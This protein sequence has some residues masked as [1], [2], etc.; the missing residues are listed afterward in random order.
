VRQSEY[1]GTYSVKKYGVITAMQWEQ[2]QADKLNAFGK[3]LQQIGA[4]FAT[5]PDQITT[6]LY[7]SNAVATYDS[8]TLLHATSH[9]ANKT[10]DALSETAVESG[11]TQGLSLTDWAGNKAPVNYDRLMVHPTL[12]GTADRICNSP[13]MIVTGL[14]STSAASTIGARNPIFKNNLSWFVNPYLTTATD[15]ALLAPPATVPCITLVELAGYTGILFFTENR[16]AG[17]YFERDVLRWKVMRVNGA[18]IQDHRLYGR[19]G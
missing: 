15:W 18:Y 8:I 19:V 12:H 10:T 5:I 6:A 13:I 4:G 14:A 3:Q 2:Q 7:T 17:S 9:G 16:D 1:S 11:I